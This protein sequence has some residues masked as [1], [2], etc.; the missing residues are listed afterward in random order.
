M[1]APVSLAASPTGAWIARRTGAQLSLHAA[2]RLSEA[3]HVE[4]ERDDVDVAF[5]GPPDQLVVVVRGAATTQVLL[6]NPPDLEIAARAEVDGRAELAAVTGQRVALVTGEHR[7]MVL[8]RCAPRAL[9]V[10]PTESGPLVEAV[11]GLEEQKLL[12]VQPKKIEQWDAVSRRPMLRLNLPL[13]PAPRLLGAAKGNFWAAQPGKDALVI[14]RASDGRP[15]EHRVGAGV[16]AVASNLASPHIAVATERGLVR[17]HAFAHT[18]T[19]MGARSAAA[20]AQAVVGEDPIL[21]GCDDAQALWKVSLADGAPIE[22][23][24]VA[25]PGSGGGRGI[26]IEPIGAAPKVSK[27]APARPSDARAWRDALCAWTEEALARHARE[28]ALARP[29]PLDDPAVPFDAALSALGDRVS[30]TGRRALALLYGAWLRGEPRLP[31]AT[32][33][34]ALGGGDEAWGEALGASSLAAAGW[35]DVDGGAIGLCRAIARHLDGAVPAAVRLVG[36]PPAR[37]APRGVVACALDEE[38]ALA[39]L[40]AIAIHQAGAS[41]DEAAL[42]ARVHDAALIVSLAGVR[43]RDVAAFARRGGDAI[44]LATGPL[45][46]RLASLPAWPP[47]PAG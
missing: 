1:T 24:V 47:P 33:A 38:A 41:L 2:A 3:L 39:R 18:T 10:Q 14:Y 42:E 19:A 29:A 43:A 20:L 5:A 6:Y 46:A 34:A 40:G 4:L 22:R 28:G 11:V 15:F 36:E 30:P 16:V 26:S 17:V 35:V 23:Q 7:T 13:P 32:V 27:L 25:S 37:E 8:V 31:I 9:V 12:V 45:P 21:Y 44:V